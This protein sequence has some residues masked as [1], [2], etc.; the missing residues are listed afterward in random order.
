[1]KKTF[2]KKKNGWNL[3][4][5]LVTSITGEEIER[6]L[7][8]VTILRSQKNFFLNELCRISSKFGR[9][10]GFC[11]AYASLLPGGFWD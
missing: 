9:Y 10:K 2:L 1:M 5:E 7:K 8:K 3:Q 6:R 4:Y 11:R